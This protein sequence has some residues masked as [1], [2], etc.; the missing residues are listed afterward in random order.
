MEAEKV[1]GVLVV[2]AWCCHHLKENF[3][4]KFGRALAL[5]FWKVA[6][7]R[8]RAAYDG[9]LNK[10]REK[11]AEAALYLESQELEKWV[12]CLFRGRR[13]GH[14]T[15][16]IAESLNQVLRFDRE[17]PVVEMLDNL[18]HR[19]MEKRAQRLLTA[20]KALAEG[21][22]T[23]PWVEGK[24]EEARTWAL[25]NIVQVSSPSK[26]RVVQPDG[27]IHLVNTTARTCSCR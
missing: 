15:S 22:L 17:L 27:S 16:N 2:V 1:L 24:V 12:E 6:Q 11:K 9:A 23:T 10:L 19:V 4:K 8:T 25:R 26:G 13:Y 3:T 7:A 5:L 14:D 18:W 20:S 21:S